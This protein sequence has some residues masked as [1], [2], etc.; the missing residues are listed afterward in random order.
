MKKHFGMDTANIACHSHHDSVAGK[1]LWYSVD[2]EERYNN[3]IKKHKNKSYKDLTY[4]INNQGFRI[5]TDIEEKEDPNSI[6]TL[7]CSITFGVG[8]EKNSTWPYIIE[9]Y[10]GRKVYNL[11]V[12][13]GSMDTFYRL[14]KYWLPILKSKNI[15]ILGHPGARRE[16]YSYKDKWLL[17]GAN[18]LVP[19]TSTAF[20]DD[21]DRLILLNGTEFWL[22]EQKNLD[23]MKYLASQHD[24]RLHYITQNG[25]KIDNEARDLEHPG[26]NYHSNV[27]EL[28]KEKV[29]GLSQTN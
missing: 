3:N 13:G 5:D 9:N 29:N 23:A 21:E 18:C 8:V 15:L 10:T 24:S 6:I 12:P 19:F 22:N 2:T 28:F 7:G 26:K 14:L 25:L 1:F 27:A 17:L 11:G 20:G 16:F 4:I